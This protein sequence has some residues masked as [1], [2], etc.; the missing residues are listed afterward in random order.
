MGEITNMTNKEIEGLISAIKD[1]TLYDY[2]ANNYYKWSKD[3]LKNILLEIIWT[4]RNYT[5]EE[6]EKELIENL[7]ERLCYD[8]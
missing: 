5:L 1:D 6:G 4:T 3:D 8:E 7:K 2:I